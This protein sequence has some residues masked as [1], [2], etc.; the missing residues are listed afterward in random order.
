MNTQVEIIGR[1]SSHFTRVATLIAHELDVPFTLVPVFDLLGSD[2][3]L[4]AGNPALKIPVLRLTSGPSHLSQSTLLFGAANIARRLATLARPDAASRLTWPDAR[5]DDLA[6]N[7]HE[8]V[9]HGMSTQVQLVV[10][11]RHPGALSQ[12]DTS[13]PI[14]R[15]EVYLAKLQRGFEGTLAWLEAHLDPLLDAL[16]PEGLASALRAGTSLTEVMLFCLVDHIRYRGTASLAPYPKLVRFTE[17]FSQRPS[18]ERTRYRRDPPLE[19]A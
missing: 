13:A 8:L 14:P 5:H 16:A 7:A 10:A 2:P 3:A 17:V 11:A 18:A 19:S 9:V 6:H 4:F 1:S 15:D 12:S